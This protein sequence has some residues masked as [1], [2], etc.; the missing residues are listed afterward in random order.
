MGAVRPLESSMP[1][2]WSS[3]NLFIRCRFPLDAWMVL[4]TLLTDGGSSPLHAGDVG[5]LKPSLEEVGDAK[6]RV[7]G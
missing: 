3:M 5:S 7:S 2:I 6:T 1:G 4:E